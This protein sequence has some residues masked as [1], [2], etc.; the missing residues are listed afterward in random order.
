MVDAD[1]SYG[2]WLLQQGRKEQEEVLGSKAPYFRMLA[3]KHGARDAMAKLVREDGRELT[4][5]QLRRRY[6]A[7]P[8]R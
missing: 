2:Q 6:G 4:L 7:T 3:R 8:K 1:T 5:E